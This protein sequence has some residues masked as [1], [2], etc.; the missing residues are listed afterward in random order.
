MALSF[1]NREPRESPPPGAG[2]KPSHFGAG[3]PIPGPREGRVAAPSEAPIRGREIAEF[4][5]PEELEPRGP[6]H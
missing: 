2:E 1:A 4:R 3:D 5:A 6:A